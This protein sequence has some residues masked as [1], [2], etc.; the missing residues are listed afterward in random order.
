[1]GDLLAIR[2]RIGRIRL[3]LFH[4]LLLEL[5]KILQIRTPDQGEIVSD[6]I[7]V[8]AAETCLNLVWEVGDEGD[9]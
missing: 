8:H 6:A 5:G 4:E 7:D 2:Q 1:M 9:E 3:A